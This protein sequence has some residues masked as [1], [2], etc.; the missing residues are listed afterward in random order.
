L[1]RV[2]V[3]DDHHI[4]CEGLRAWVEAHDALDWSGCALD[5]DALLDRATHEPWDALLLDLSLPGCPSTELIT[6]VR[7]AQPALRIIVYSMYP[8][9]E[10]ANWTLAAGASAYVCKS[11]PLAA[12][13]QALLAQAPPAVTPPPDDARLAHEKLA[14]R[15]RAVFLAIA[16]GCTPSQIAWELA[17]APS[18]VSTHLKGVRKKLGVSSTL[19]VAQYAAR[20]GIAAAREE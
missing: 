18:T 11:E 15:E 7:A 17:M 9:S 6:R 14:P 8:A 16:R 3:A 12:L 19:E 10:Y 2:F 20:H 1:V 5:A 4:V 13:L